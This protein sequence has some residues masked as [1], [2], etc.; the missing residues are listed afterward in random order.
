V[1]SFFSIFLFLLPFLLDAQQLLIREI[2]FE[3]LNRTRAQYIEGFLTLEKGVGTSLEQLEVNRQRLANLEVLSDVQLEIDTLDEGLSLTFDCKELY[4]LL[5]ILGFGGIAENFWLQ[6]G[7]TDVNLLGRGYK[8]YLAY[9]YYDRHSISAHLSFDWVNNS[10]WG[11]NVNFVKWSTLEPLYFDAGQVNY[12]YDNYTYGLDGIYHF[13][14]RDKLLVGGAY[15][16]EAYDATGELVAD[17]PAYAFKRKWLMKVMVEH[18]RSNWFYYFRDGWQH[19]LHAQTVYTVD[20]P[21]FYMVFNDLKYYDRVGQ[22]GNFAS[23]LRM[24]LSSN[25]ESPFAPFVLDSYLNIRGVGNRVDRGTGSVV[26]NLEYRHT[27]LESK[28]IALQA[29]AFSDLGTWRNP[30]GSLND[31]AEVENIQSFAGFGV[32]AI[33]K[34]IFNAILRLDYGVDLQDLSRSGFVVGIGQYF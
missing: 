3:G 9:Q 27:F 1:R 7:V 32:R 28:K 24:G 13:N 23:R 22:R 14:F 25:Q 10:P 21:S 19:Q 15:F 34:E 20:E 5:P 2:T 18:D 30:G 17:A 16:T 29:V 6:G 31:F 8:A 4:A 12:N 33:H 26:L 11:F